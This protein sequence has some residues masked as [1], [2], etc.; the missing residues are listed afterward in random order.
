MLKLTSFVRSEGGVDHVLV[1]GLGVGGQKVKVH[2]P[3]ADVVSVGSWFVYREGPPSWYNTTLAKRHTT[4]LTLC[5]CG[6]I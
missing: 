2:V 4:W 3:W 5:M 1:R 6:S